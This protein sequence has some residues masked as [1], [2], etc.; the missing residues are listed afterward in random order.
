MMYFLNEFKII[1]SSPC[2]KN[3]ETSVF[4]ILNRF[5]EKKLKLNERKKLIEKLPSVNHL[6]KSNVKESIVKIK[7]IQQKKFFQKKYILNNFSSQNS[8]RKILPM[9]FTFKKL[10]NSPLKFFF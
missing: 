8:F 10:K 5:V 9:Q 1:S 6:K 2:K 4:R 3:Q 7:I